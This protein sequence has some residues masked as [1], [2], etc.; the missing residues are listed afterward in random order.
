[1]IKFISKLTG[2]V[3]YVAEDRKEEY[4]AAGHALAVE[5]APVVTRTEEKTAPKKAP[6]RKKK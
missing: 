1:M 3:M 5:E 6:A 2:N 4:L